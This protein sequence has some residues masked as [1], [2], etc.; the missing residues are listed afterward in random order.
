MLAE[1]TT[2]FGLEKSYCF[3][4]L[5]CYA[6]HGKTLHTFSQSSAGPG[7]KRIVLSPTLQS[8]LHIHDPCCGTRQEQEFRFSVWFSVL[9]VDNPSMAG[10]SHS[11][12]RGTQPS[13]SV[14]RA[15]LPLARVFEC[16]LF[17]FEE[18]LS[19]DTRTCTWLNQLTIHNMFFR[20]NM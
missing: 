18:K 11:T 8:S 3:L 5:H 19:F 10:L 13:C 15:P 16:Y 7:V 1:L 17:A 14:D 9:Q 20:R 6:F 12:T 2:T 4:C